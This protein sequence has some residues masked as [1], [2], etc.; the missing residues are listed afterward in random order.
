M[1]SFVMYI[2]VRNVLRQTY[3][4]SNS[5]CVRVT[6]LGVFARRACLDA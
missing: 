4:L 2:H 5:T 6:V 1:N 3:L